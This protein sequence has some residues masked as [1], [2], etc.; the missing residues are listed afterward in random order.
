[1]KTPEKITKELK[2]FQKE[3]EKLCRK[4]EVQGVMYGATNELKHPGGGVFHA[5]FAMVSCSSIEDITVKQARS[6]L[7]TL[8]REDRFEEL[9]HYVAHDGFKKCKHDDG[10]SEES[11]RSEKERLESAVEGLLKALK[12]LDD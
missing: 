2:S 7:E 12:E 3:F 6:I 11:K 9:G 1:M 4:Y 8:R 10:P 5:G